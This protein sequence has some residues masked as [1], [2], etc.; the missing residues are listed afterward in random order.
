M[1]L[2]YAFCNV[3]LLPVRAEPAHRAEMTTQLLFGERAEVLE[4]NEDEW[5]R[6]HCRWDNYIGWCKLSQLT[7]IPKKEYQKEAKYISSTN[8]GKL[9]FEEHEQWLPLGSELYGIKKLYE[10][11]AKFKGKRQLVS[12]LELTPM[13]LAEAAGRYMNAP[14]LWGGRSIAGIDCSGL[15]Q[16]AFKLCG[17]DILR[18]ASQQA[19]QGEQVDFLQHAQ[20][21][22]L[23]FF[24][25]KE[26]NINHV[27]LL[28]D[29]NHIIHATDTSGKVVVDKIDQ[30]GIISK[31]LRMRT[32]SLRMIKRYC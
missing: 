9:L 6:I 19:T 27:G 5:A 13:R 8:N 26:G 21:G 12:E 23:A 4:I 11:P 32:H 30:G 16:M 25:N 1:V 14:Y 20:T 24:E 7:I 3:S 29:S 22:D 17:K 28:L 18:D 2:S 10:Q 15:T 31:R